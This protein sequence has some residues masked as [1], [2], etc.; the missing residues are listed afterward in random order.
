MLRRSPLVLGHAPRPRARG[1]RARRTP[2]ATGVAIALTAVTAWLSA[3]TASAHAAE[4]DVAVCESAL[5]E[6]EA[7][8]STMDAMEDALQTNQETIVGLR[9]EVSK[10]EG[11]IHEGST[12]GLR[13]QL[14]DAKDALAQARRRTP[15]LER[16]LAAVSRNFESRAREYFA[17]VDDAL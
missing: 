3:P 17:C 11:R 7:L 14:A 16:Q 5:A 10:I 15:V 13:L 9:D 8:Q 2:I 1:Q 12:P 4:Q 6:V